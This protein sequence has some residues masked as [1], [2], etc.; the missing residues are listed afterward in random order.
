MEILGKLFGSEE[1]VRIMR[2]FLFNPE[3]V[4]TV[5]DI[6]A[7]SQISKRIAEKEIAVLKKIGLIKK[8]VALRS[9]EKKKGKE[10][11]IT[12]KKVGGFALDNG[13][14]YLSVLQNLLIKTSIPKD[15]DLVHKL[16]SVGRLKAVVISGVFTQDSE[17]RVD[18]LLVGD[19]LKRAPLMN[20]VKAIESEIGKELRYA[21][22]ETPEFQYRLGMYDKLI[23]D[24][25]DFPHK[26]ILDKIGLVNQK[27]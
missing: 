14:P 22:F 26:K 19:N 9:F 23:W 13:F 24:I 15:N 21:A 10:I 3:H 5:E 1:K 17:S 11:K 18:L 16:E 27:R 4:Y 8:R 20:V 7:R 25:L 12:R 2:L 6:V